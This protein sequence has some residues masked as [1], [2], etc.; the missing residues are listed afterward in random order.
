MEVKERKVELIELFYDLIYVYAIA[1]MTKLLEEP[2]DGIITAEMFAH[3]FILSM[4]IIQAWLYMTNYVNHYCRW[5]WYEYLA[6]VINMS[7]AIVMSQTIS[8]S[9]TEYTRSL[10]SSMMVMFACIASLYYLECRS[11]E[12]DPEYARTTS[13]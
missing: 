7:A 5:R 2:V 13:R 10:I 9:W 8:E 4:V 6:V 3:Y 12:D 1:N 11:G